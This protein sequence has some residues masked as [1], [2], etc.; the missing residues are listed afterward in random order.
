MTRSLTCTSR[1]PV[2]PRYRVVFEMGVL[3]DICRWARLG[4]ETRYKAERLGFLFG[5]VGNRRTVVVKRAVLYRG[6]IR[7]RTSAV[8]AAAS[9]IRRR[10]KLAR[11][12]GLRALGL[13]HS[14]VE[15]GGW[16][17][18]GLTPGEAFENDPVSVIEAVVAVRFAGRKPVRTSRKVLFG[19]EPDTGYTY[20]IRV[21][22]RTER[23]VR[24]LPVRATD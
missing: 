21:Y 8:C 11:A 2:L 15:V 4:Y 6:G 17:V 5:H 24:L 20:N 22:G 7:T 3:Q 13:F 9:L 19:F 10:R 1:W 12:L 16:V 23:G 18:H 14:H